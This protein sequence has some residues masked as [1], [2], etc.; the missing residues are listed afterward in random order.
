MRRS[1]VDADRCAQYDNLKKTELEVALDDH[2]SRNSSTYASDSRFRPFYKRRSESS[3]VK[4][5]ASSALSDLEA[6]GKAVKRRATKAA[7]DI[8]NAFNNATS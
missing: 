8:A 7:E 2:L 3:P 1:K 6:K 5:E 4:K